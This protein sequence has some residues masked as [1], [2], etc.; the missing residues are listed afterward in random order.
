VFFIA[1]SIRDFYPNTRFRVSIGAEC[2][3]FDAASRYTWSK[4]LDI[5]WHWVDSVDFKRW[6]GTAHPYIATMMDRFKPPF[7]TDYV[8]MLDADVIAIAPFDELFEHIGIA[9]VMAHGSPFQGDHVNTWRRLFRAYGL[10][11]PTFEYEHSGWQSMFVDEAQRLSPF[12]LNT[13]VVFGPRKTYEELYDP[14][15]SALDFVRSMLDSYFFEQIGLT[16]AVQ[17]TAI[18]V[19][20]LPLRFNFPNQPEFDKRHPGELQ[21]VRLLHFLRTDI[22]NRETDFADYVSVKSLTERGD[23]SGSNEILRSRIHALGFT[24]TDLNARAYP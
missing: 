20:L 22:I 14:Y 4:K 17:R 18:P 12:Y 11:E 21:D 16:L 6:S 10:A 19:T 9:G 5:E 13:G 8:L 1:R 23:L 3:P 2:R 24:T 15:M 7:E